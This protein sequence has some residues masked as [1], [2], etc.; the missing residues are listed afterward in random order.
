VF[1]SIIG[2][3]YFYQC[4][5]FDKIKKNF[6]YYQYE[7]KPVEKQECSNLFIQTLFILLTKGLALGILI[8]MLNLSE[9]EIERVYWDYQFSVESQADKQTLAALDAQGKQ[10]LTGLI[11]NAILA[12]LLVMSVVINCQAL[13]K[14]LQDKKTKAHH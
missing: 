10:A 5:C 9:G 2:L 6:V 7:A 11:L 13:G 1:D 8:T 4:P 3:Y 14:P 12:G